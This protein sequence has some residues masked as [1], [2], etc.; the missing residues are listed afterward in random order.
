MQQ[1]VSGFLQQ[2]SSFSLM[3]IEN[4]TGIWK[5]SKCYRDVSKILIVVSLRPKNERRFRRK[6]ELIYRKIILPW[7]VKFLFRKISDDIKNVKEHSLK[8][9][10]LAKRIRA[11]VHQFFRILMDLFMT[12]YD[13]MTLW[14]VYDHTSN[15]TS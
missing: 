8:M 11:A 7:N 1:I 12:S 6:S 10:K 14:L 15:S 13:F 3:M 4:F 5:L 2:I 9:P